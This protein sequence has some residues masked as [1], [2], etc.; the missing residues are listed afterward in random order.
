MPD[1]A[2]LDWLADA[3]PAPLPLDSDTTARVRAEL[4]G[5]AAAAETGTRRA[6]A[7]GRR[8]RGLG[9]RAL[10]I[11]VGGVTLAGAASVALLATGGGS[12]H[13]SS[14]G[15]GQLVVQNASAKQLHHLSAT[16][17]AAPPPVGDAT[18]VV[19]RQTYPSS[20]EIDGADLYA[21]N[22]NYYYSPTVAGLPALIKTGETVDDGSQD[23]EVRDMA[24]ARAALTGPIGAARQQMSVANYANGVKPKMVSPGQALKNAPAAMRQQLEQKLAEVKR[25]DQ[26]DNMR[27]VISQADG[28]IWDNGMDALLAGAGDPQVRSGVIK[29]FLTIPQISVTNGTL[30]GQP[31]LNLT[32]SLQSSNSGLYQEELILNASTGVPMEMLGGNKG[33]TPTVTVYYTISRVTVADVESGSAS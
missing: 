16:L 33:Q 19:R 6:P 17:A 3:R 27:S 23:A 20:A 10:R 7:R 21:D 24:A 31:T 22:G 2:E 28:L 26:Q 11:A 1:Q 8:Q 9:R 5:H 30:D 29:L 4:L 32:A 12:G 15:L 18:L 25:H 14:G 13:P